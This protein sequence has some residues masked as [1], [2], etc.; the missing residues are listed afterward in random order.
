MVYINKYTIKSTPSF[1]RE[2]ENIYNYIIYTLKE[3]STAK[4]FYTQVT[5]KIYSLE[6]FPERYTKISTFKNKWGNIRRL[7]FDKYAIIYDVDNTTHQ[8][9]IIHIFNNTQNYLNLL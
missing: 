7:T 9:F 3:P 1:E 6:Y 4:N 5:K 8:V 2:F